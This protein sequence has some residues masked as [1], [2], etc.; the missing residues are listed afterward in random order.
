MVEGW[1]NLQIETGRRMITK[2]SQF[3]L[4]KDYARQPVPYGKR[5][6]W[7]P[8]ALIWL[9]MGIDLSAVVLGAALINGMTLNQAILA[10][11]AGSVIL[12]VIGAFCSYVGSKT[13]LSTAMINRFTFGEKGAYLVIL[14]MSVAVFGWFGVTAGF[15]GQSAHAVLQSVF[16]IEIP[17]RWLALIGGLLMTATAAIG[18]KAI[19]KLS[20]ISVPLMV[21]F[22]LSMLGVLITRESLAPIFSMPP[23]ETMGLGTAISLV[24][25]AYII[26][27]A[28]SPDVARWAKTSRD[29][30]L[31]GFFGF[32]VGNSLMMFVAAFLSR[33][34][35]TEDVI[36]ILLSF[37]WGAIAVTLL[38]LAQW[39]TNDNNMYCVGLNL[40]VLFKNVP[41][42]TLTIIAGLA[43]TMLAFLGI[44]GKFV[45]FLLLLSPFAAPVAGIYLCEYFLVNRSK[46]Q[47]AFLAEREIVAVR[48][49]SLLVW[50]LATMIAF[51][52]T[53]MTD[54]GLGWFT[55][56]HVSTLDGLLSA[57]VLQY[58]IGKAGMSQGMTKKPEVSG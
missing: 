37:G 35:G 8:L 21:G 38:V 40:S 9:A 47:F 36:Q 22:L 29:A 41:K 54:G 3:M 55:L 7:L 12:G 17:P 57:I 2:K 4:D 34:T 25:G 30:A 19:E 32:L 56:T 46:F 18:Y 26:G 52:T 48:W 28:Q 27:C 16:G 14:V 45:D 58:V 13:G 43:G 44:Y 31:S 24:V 11:T 20:M 5:R 33:L 1:I 50:G 53:P 15:F 51:A 42:I 39:T 49:Q 10:I 23:K 6:G